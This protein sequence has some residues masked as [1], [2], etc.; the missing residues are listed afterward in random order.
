[1]SLADFSGTQDRA[2][3]FPHF[4]VPELLSERTADALLDWFDSGAPWTLKIADFYE[5][6]EFSLIDAVLPD[7]LS[8]FASGDFVSAVGGELSARLKAPALTLVDICAHRLLQGQ[9][10]R[11]HNDDIGEGE[12]HRLV[13]QLNRGWAVEQGGLL[14]MF[15]GNDP[16]SVTDVLMPAH[17]SAFGFEISARSFHAVSTVHAGSRDTLVYTFRRAA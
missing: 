7:N 4:L 15:S 11:I 13:V 5:Q 1:M 17:R 12:T 16:E 10:I 3:P 2:A 9:T 6:H 8:H 14:M